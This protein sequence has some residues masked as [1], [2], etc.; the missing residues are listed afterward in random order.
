[1]KAIYIPILCN[2]P[3]TEAVTELVKVEWRPKVSFISSFWRKYARIFVLGYYLFREANSKTVSF[4]YS[5]TPLDEKAQ[6]FT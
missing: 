2:Q 4:V 1:M 6:E 5:L 3:F